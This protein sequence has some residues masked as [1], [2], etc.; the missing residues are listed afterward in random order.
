MTHHPPVAQVF[1]GYNPR[2]RVAVNV[3]TDSIQAHASLPVQIAQV[4]L[5]QLG[6]VYQRPQDP[7]QSTAFS[8]SRFLVP[9]LMGY[10]GSAM[11][12]R[13]CR[14]FSTSTSVK[15]AKSS[16]GCPKPPIGART[17]RR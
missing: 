9:Y 12:A 3:L 15:L 5:E 6:S 11:K 17:G 8:F 10:E 1:I 4:R 13:Q 16:R 7:L 2:E 14:W